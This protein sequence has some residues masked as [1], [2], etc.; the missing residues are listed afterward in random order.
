MKK[1]RNHPQT[2]SY[3]G[4]TLGITNP[5]PM[6]IDHLPREISPGTPITLAMRTTAKDIYYCGGNDGTMRHPPRRNEAQ[7]TRIAYALIGVFDHYRLDPDK[8]ACIVIRSAIS[9]KLQHVYLQGIEEMSF[10]I[11]PLDALA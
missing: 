11:Q 8:P 5:D 9:R 6:H 3:A 10:E 4:R 7:L 2:D 1:G